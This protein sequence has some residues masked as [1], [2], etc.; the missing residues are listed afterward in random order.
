HDVGCQL[1]RR[2]VEGDLH[3]IDD[4]GHGLFDCS[5]DLFGRHD[6][7]LGQA[8][9]EVPTTY[10]R[11]EF[12]LQLVGRAEGDLDLLCRALAEGQT[13]FLLHECD[14][15]FI[16]LVAADA[17][18]LARHDAAQRDDR[19]L[20]GASADVDHHVAGW[21][22]HGEAGSDGGCHRLFDDVRGPCAS[23]FRCF[24]HS[25][26]FDAGNT[27]RHA[28]HHA[29][30]GEAAL[31][32]AMDEIPQHLLADLEICDH[33]VFERADRLDV[34]RCPADHPLRLCSYGQRASV[35]DVDRDHGGL[36]QD[37]AATAHVDEGV[38]GTQVDVHVTTKEGKA[39]VGHEGL[40]P[41]VCGTSTGRNPVPVG[42]VPG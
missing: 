23:V 32:H 39:I 29:R 8:A 7:G 22:V 36:V 3:G 42:K 21:L 14:D 6:D 31:M 20:R 17:H 30:L 26:P 15:R 13:E 27:R 37:D 16:E 25:P 19:D 9:H 40:S 38:G 12:L 10:L 18:R 35:F 33:A 4:G 24:H 5:P 34:R 41:G 1:G 28:D 2:A 11:M